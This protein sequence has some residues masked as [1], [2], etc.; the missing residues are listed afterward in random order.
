MRCTCTS[1]SS[2]ALL[3]FTHIISENYDKFQEH[4][5][6]RTAMLVC[7]CMRE[8]HLANDIILTILG[9][10]VAA[11]VVSTHTKATTISDKCYGF[12]WYILVHTVRMSVFY[13]KH[14]GTVKMTVCILYGVRPP[15]C[16]NSM[17]V[18]VL[19]Y[20]QRISHI[21]RNLFQHNTLYT[22]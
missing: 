19:L 12:C 2:L 21:F 15:M 6:Q 14:S 10:F 11:K 9:A 20:A 1:C 3:Y 22:A 16:C 13:S 18:Y 7:D 5:R 17:F 4:G 8:S